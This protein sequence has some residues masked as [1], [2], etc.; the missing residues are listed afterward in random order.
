MRDLILKR[1]IS[2]DGFV[3][4]PHGGIKWVLPSLTCVNTFSARRS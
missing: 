2:I 3:G 1:S 4:G